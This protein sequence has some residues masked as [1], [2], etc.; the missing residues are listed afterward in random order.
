MAWTQTEID[1]LKSA[2]ARGVKRVR[3][4]GEEVEYSTITEMR[5]A[6]SMMEAEVN[7]RTRNG[8]AVTYPT[9]SRGL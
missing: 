5:T 8:F 9:T 1:A 2:I 4:N 6:L 7:G 3:M